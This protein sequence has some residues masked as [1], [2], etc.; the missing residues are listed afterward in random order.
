MPNSIRTGDIVAD[1]Y[2]MLDLLHETEGGL[3]WR[4]FDQ[5]LARHVAFH[6][7]GAT[8]PRAP[9]LLE[10]AKRSATVTDSRILRVL[11]ADE[12]SGICFVVNEWGSGQSLDILLADGPLSPRRAAWIVSEVAETIAKAHGLGQAHGRLVPENVLIDHNG[13]VKIIGFAV[14][15]A[16]HGLPAGRRSTDTVDLAGLLYACLVGKWPGVSSST[17]PRAPQEGGQPLRPRKVRAGIPKPLDVVCDEVLSP[18]AHTAGSHART[19]DSAAAI[20]EALIDFVGDPGVL[21]AAEKD[22]APTVAWS[23]PV[24]FGPQVAPVDP[25][26]GHLPEQQPEARTEDSPAPPSEA[27]A[28][29]DPGATVAGVPVFESEWLTPRADPPPPPPRF[30]QPPERPLYAPDPVRRPRDPAAEG[31]S[32]GARP[33]SAGQASGAPASGTEYWPWD[34]GH[35]ISHPTNGTGTGPIVDADDDEGRIP[36]RS[37]LRLAALIAAAA[38]LLTAVAFAIA[39][40]RDGSTSDPG[41]D[42]T[43]GGPGSTADPGAAVKVVGV[44]DF[45]PQG[46]PPEEYPEL[47]DN[48]IDGDRGT[49]WR[50]SS[51][52]QDFGP[53]GLK[54]GVGLVLDLGSAQPVGQV[55]LDLVGSPTSVSVYVLAKAPTQVPGGDPSGSGTAQ[56]DALSV[57][58]PEDTTGRF[59]L[60]WLTSLP[61]PENGSFRGEI[62]EIVV[63]S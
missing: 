33:G 41:T 15:A 26:F 53:G 44:T 45:D 16:L 19:I 40:T 56:G 48:A 10:A 59:V 14:D 36:G 6:V 60:V 29:P 52:L 4:A 46:D 57:E 9:L 42:P 24:P 31:P 25:P 35:P 27:E 30:E 28:A 34:T 49:S 47:A 17:L 2:R 7:I 13:S 43:T 18:F 61:E 20:H 5:I 63:R 8:D 55:D 21:A 39:L 32:T 50:T 54:D 37:F 22:H 62:S 51:Y 58:L 12:R 38:L 1:R 23:A 11:D 3:F